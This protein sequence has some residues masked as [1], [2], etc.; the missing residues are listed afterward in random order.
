MSRTQTHP[1][2]EQARYVAKT[3]DYCVANLHSPVLDMNCPIVT[4]ADAPDPDEHPCGTTAC[5]AGFY[6]WAYW[7]RQPDAYFVPVSEGDHNYNR[8][9]ANE[10]LV[11]DERG[12]YNALRNLHYTRGA[13]R[14]AYDLGFDGVD[15]QEQLESWADEY[16]AR[17]GNRDGGGMFSSAKAFVSDEYKHA[18]PATVYL[19]EIAAHWHGVADRLAQR[20]ANQEAQTD[21]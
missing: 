16:P 13:A 3:F 14:M 5:H 21:E 1:T 7:S 18:G 2:A 11:R 19:S 8:E 6:E 15:A 12:G 9:R 20:E 4:K 10:S 17:W